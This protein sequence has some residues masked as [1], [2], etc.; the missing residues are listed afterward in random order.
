MDSAMMS[1]IAYFKSNDGYEFSQAV[2][3]LA[4]ELTPAFGSG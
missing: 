4:G 2:L 1:Q 3:D